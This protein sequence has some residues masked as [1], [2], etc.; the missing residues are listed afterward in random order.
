MIIPRH[1]TFMI[2]ASGFKFFITRSFFINMYYTR[3]PNQ[4][5]NANVTRR[6]TYVGDV[7]LND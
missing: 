2:S 6:S 4:T 7:L 3:K 1:C 5:A